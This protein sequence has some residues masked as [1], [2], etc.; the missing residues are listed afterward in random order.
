MNNKL[1][2]IG[3]VTGLVVAMVGCN[4][5]DA[6]KQANKPAKASE[7]ILDT[8]VYD[9][10]QTAEILE[11]ALGKIKLTRNTS[12]RRAN[13]SL[14]QTNLMAML[15]DVDEYP[16]VVNAQDSD[17]IEAVEIFTSS[18]KSGEGRDGIFV[19]L[20]NQFNEQNNKLSNGKTA[21]IAIRKIAS[22]LASQY[23]IS[24]RYV[25]DAYSP[26]NELWVSMI[27]DSGLNLRKIR[28]QTVG[29]VGGIVIRKTKLDLISDGKGGY[30]IE[31]LLGG[32]TQGQIAMGYTNPFVSSTGLN[33]LITMLER[34]AGGDQDSML[35]PEV[36]SAFEAFQLGVP[37]VAQTTLQM[38]HAVEGSGVL[39]AM[40]M[41][42]QT[43]NNIRSLQNE[44]EFIPFGYRHDNP[45][46]AT[47]NADSVEMEVLKAYGEMIDNQK[48]KAESYGFF[49]FKDYKSAFDLPKGNV[50]S[51][52]QKLWKEKKSGGRPIAAIFIADVSGSMDGERLKSL[53]KVLLESADLISSSN[54]I[55]LI[56]FNNSVNVDLPV[57]PFNL[58]HKASFVGAVEI[59]SAGGG[60][61]TY[62]AVVVGLDELR[63]FK[64][65][66][67]DHK[68]VL[69]VLSDGDQ[70]SGQNFNDISKLVRSIGIPVH[71][72]AY[73][74]DSDEL[75]KLSQLVEAAYIET[76][77]GNAGYK[78][79][80]LLNAE[81]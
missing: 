51:R 3:I 79:G 39:D 81:M 58:S 61:A 60:T 19:E 43:F 12:T 25:P 17:S 63:K 1:L 55:G 41:E 64:K 70:T 52:A 16:M 24:G 65:Q 38:R 40:V 71:S 28:E 47:P 10:S 18:E 23:M 15:P 20:A 78:I 4:G 72:I 49:G 14:T 66:N 9:E 56:S 50:L 62:D 75:K 76:N 73:S 36:A 35:L 37:F 46:V 6:N 21:K 30:S 5:N 44:Y 69:F 74:F 22:G 68:T 32:V 80:N 42:Y 31:A 67:P 27:N 13:I 54:S 7:K 45:L 34:F 57:K 8:S 2:S 77:L 29:N 53:K 48:A 26:S 59:L 11:N 33:F